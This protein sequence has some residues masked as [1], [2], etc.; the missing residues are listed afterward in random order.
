MDINLEPSELVMRG[1]LSKCGKEGSQW[2]SW[3]GDYNAIEQKRVSSMSPSSWTMFSPTGILTS[4][5]T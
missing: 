4:G 5:S 1:G 2:F 3:D